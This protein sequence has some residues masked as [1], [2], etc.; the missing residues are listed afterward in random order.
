[1]RFETQPV[2]AL[3]SKKY[4]HCILYQHKYWHS[5][6][7]VWDAAQTDSGRQPGTLPKLF[8]LACRLGCSLRQHLL[9][10]TFFFFNTTSDTGCI[11]NHPNPPASCSPYYFAHISANLWLSQKPHTTVL[12]STSAEPPI[13]TTM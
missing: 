12:H 2:T 3:F 5:R 7:A 6:T 10:F 13:V 4:K 9:L 8:L 1:M 11:R